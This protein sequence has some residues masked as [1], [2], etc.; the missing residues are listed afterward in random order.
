MWRDFDS[1]RECLW[2]HCFPLSLSAGCKLVVAMWARGLDVTR[3]WVEP[4]PPYALGIG[5]I[6]LTA[7][8]VDL[9]T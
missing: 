2:G 1:M 8:E 3:V 7:S 5:R 6:S 4:A 9:W